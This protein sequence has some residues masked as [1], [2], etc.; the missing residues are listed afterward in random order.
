MTDDGSGG[1]IPSVQTELLDRRCPKDEPLIFPVAPPQGAHLAL[2]KTAFIDFLK[3]C[4]K[5]T[6]HMYTSP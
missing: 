5:Y 1:M 4:R 6:S 3:I 2:N